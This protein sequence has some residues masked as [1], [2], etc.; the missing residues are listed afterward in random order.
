MT[1]DSR[2]GL[3]ACTH[4]YTHKTQVR[5]STCNLHA[6]GVGLSRNLS[7]PEF[8]FPYLQPK[9]KNKYPVRCFAVGMK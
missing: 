5:M 7:L 9:E 2:D 8:Q 1:D 4:T 3:L 6:S